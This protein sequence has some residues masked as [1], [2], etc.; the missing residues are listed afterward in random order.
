M[1]TMQPKD[2]YSEKSNDLTLADALHL[3]YALN[4]QFTIWSDYKSERAKQLVKAH[5]I[6][7]ILFGCDTSLLGEMRVQ[8][9]AKFGVK[10]FGLRESFLYAKDKEAR[11]LLKNP[12]GY[13]AMLKFFLQ[14]LDEVGAV[15]AESKKMSQKWTYFEEDAYMTSKIGD[16]RRRFNISILP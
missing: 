5:D 7:H 11:V 6:T 4:P 16:I 8:L 9:W 12:V 1:N 10:K 15:R 13:L 2:F 14:H 3:H